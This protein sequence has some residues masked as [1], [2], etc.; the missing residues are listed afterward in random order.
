MRFDIINSITEVF[1][2]IHKVGCLFHFK[3]ALKR[4]LNTLGLYRAEYIQESDRILSLCGSLPFSLNKDSAIFENIIKEISKTENYKEFADYF[5]TQWNKYLKKNNL[6][7]YSCVSRSFRTNS[8]LENYNGRIKKI[9]GNKGLIQWPKL[10]SFFLD[11]EDHYKK[12]LTNWDNKRKS[13]TMIN[14]SLEYQNNYICNKTIGNLNINNNLN[15]TIFNN[16]L[17][18]DINTENY[19]FFNYKNQSCWVDCFLFIF[20]TLIYK[21]YKGEL[22]NNLKLSPQLQCFLED[23]SNINDRSILY[24]GIWSY[25]I[26]N[27]NYQD[28]ILCNKNQLMR[29][30]SCISLFN[31]FNK[32]LEFCIQYKKISHCDICK[33][34]IENKDEISSCIFS[35]DDEDIQLGNIKSIYKH[36]YSSYSSGCPICIK[37]NIESNAFV[38]I[39]DIR[40]PKIIIVALEFKDFNP[41]VDLDDN[42]LNKGINYAKK[43]FEKKIDLNENNN[44]KTYCLKGFVIFT[45]PNHFISFIYSKDEKN[46][47]NEILL[48]YDD[49]NNGK[50]IKLKNY[51]INNLFVNG[52]PQILIYFSE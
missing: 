34:N 24:N 26:N 8:L 48:K 23:I 7:D 19:I 15:N 10:I 46:E 11:E 35:I 6:L 22:I 40:L 32:S 1:P 30:S 33:G 45:K 13:K 12:V 16:N 44:I 47:Q 4:K 29:Q 25:I 3:Q 20:K 36:R 43:I 5:R 17:D 27:N 51:D 28:N 9:L 38:L 21:N 2:S 42:I 37:K 39:S 14:K 49:L 31:I 18:F 50:I 41:N 52:F